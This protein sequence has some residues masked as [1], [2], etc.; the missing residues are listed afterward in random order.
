M[1]DMKQHEQTAM[2]MNIPAIN[3]LR[4]HIVKNYDCSSEDDRMK[5]GATQ[6]CILCISV[7]FPTHVV[8]GGP[9]VFH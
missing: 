9:T 4:I 6:E 5:R 3:E 8:G 2:Q 7:T 1:T